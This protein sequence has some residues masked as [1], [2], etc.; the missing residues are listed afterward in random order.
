M[1]A[2]SRLVILRGRFA[3]AGI[4][5]VCVRHVL[6]A[7]RGGHE[8]GLDLQISPAAVREESAQGVSI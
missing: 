1:F 8:R 4:F 2:R 6:R 5:A 7:S 3:A